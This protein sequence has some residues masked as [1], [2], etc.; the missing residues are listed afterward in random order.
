MV[1]YNSEY[2]KIK[3]ELFVSKDKTKLLWTPVYSSHITKVLYAKVWDENNKLIKDK[4]L[5]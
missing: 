4:K 3:G 2:S 1:A 5:L